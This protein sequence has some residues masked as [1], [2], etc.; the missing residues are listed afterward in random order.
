MRLNK[1]T[2]IP[3]CR[4][5]RSKVRNFKRFNET[6]FIRELSSI[7]WYVITQFSNPND[8]WQIWKSLFLEI[9]DKHAPL[10]H[11]CI[12]SNP[13]PWI[14]SNIKKL[15]RSRDFHKKRAKRYNSRVH[16]DKYKSER[17]KVNIEMR[18]S[19]SAYYQTKIKE[20]SQAKDVKKNMEVDQ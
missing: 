18:R 19:K 20:V 11:K 8:C 17:N 16:W 12:K 5:T 15:M 1:K 7:P 6:D 2:S 4:Q 9:V 14:N 10:F 3:K 13:V